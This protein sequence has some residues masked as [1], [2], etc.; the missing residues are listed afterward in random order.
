MEEHGIDSWAKRRRH[1]VF[2]FDTLRLDPTAV[3]VAWVVRTLGSATVDGPNPF[4]T[5]E[6]MVEARTCW[7]LRGNQTMGNQN[8]LVFTG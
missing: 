2:R 8:L 3:L 5:N 7:Y 4:R 6:T 1:E